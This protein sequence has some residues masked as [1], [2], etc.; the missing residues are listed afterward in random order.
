MD[1]VEQV[2]EAA[3]GMKVAYGECLG[4]EIRLTFGRIPNTTI[5]GMVIPAWETVIRATPNPEATYIYCEYTLRGSEGEGKKFFL[6]LVEKHKLR[7]VR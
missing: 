7:V 4:C 1:I 2:A 5:S 6:T 3:N